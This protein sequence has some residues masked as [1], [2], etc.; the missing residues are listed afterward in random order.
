M[1]IKFG[2]T[3]KQYLCRLGRFSLARSHLALEV[4]TC[5]QLLLF[6]KQN[7]FTLFA[8]HGI[9]SKVNNNTLLAQT[10]LY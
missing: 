7:T 10:V 5:N 4:M 2:S 6:T 1:K 3:E 9:V 8:M